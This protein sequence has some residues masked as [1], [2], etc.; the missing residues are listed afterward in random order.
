MSKP[1]VIKI[2]D[3]AYVRQDAVQP[4]TSSDIR[5]VIL[6][7]GWIMVGFFSQDGANCLL[8][9]ASVIRVWGTTKGLG[10]IA[11]GGPTNTTK[12]DP[13]PP[14]RF[15]ELTV[16]ATLDCRRDKWEKHLS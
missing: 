12:L 1:E 13:C 7:R 2:D 6:Q 4:P 11:I 9:K 10:E 5:I 16:I 8:E 15:H 14:V 3:V